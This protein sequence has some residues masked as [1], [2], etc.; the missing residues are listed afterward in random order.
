MKLRVFGSSRDKESGLWQVYT[1]DSTSERLL[2][3]ASFTEQVKAETAAFDLV[4]AS[5]K[6]QEAQVLEEIAR[7]QYAPPF[8]FHSLIEAAIHLL[9]YDT[10]EHSEVPQPGTSE[11]SVRRT[12]LDQ[13]FV[14]TS[15]N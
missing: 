6:G 10:I 13:I 14:V 7:N 8:G 12:D 15:L 3:L 5:V 11:V 1:Y 2:A 4:H 9:I